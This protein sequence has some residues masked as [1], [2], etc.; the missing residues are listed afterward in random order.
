M[1]PDVRVLGRHSGIN[2]RWVRRQV[3]GH[4]VWSVRKSKGSLPAK[5]GRDGILSVL[6]AVACAAVILG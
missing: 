4:H 3:P 5:H 6:P 2:G 1:L